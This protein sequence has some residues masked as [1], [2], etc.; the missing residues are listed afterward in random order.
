MAVSCASWVRD[1][2]VNE[3]INFKRPNLGHC[4]VLILN[5]REPPHALGSG[6]KTAELFHQEILKMKKFKLAALQ[7]NSQWDRLDETEE[8]RL[9]RAMTEG[10][11]KGLDYI[12]L[13][14]VR[15]YYSG[16]LTDTRVRIRVRLIELATRTTVFLAENQETFSSKDGG[17]MDASLAEKAAPAERAAARVVWELV[18]R[19]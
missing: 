5:F 11:E 13:G 17:F 6:V 16:G 8:E 2:N 1:R 19:I 4:S 10:E 15:E 12:L 14:D 18:K 9:L 3:I 7:V